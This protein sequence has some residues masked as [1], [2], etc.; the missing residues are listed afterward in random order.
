VGADDWDDGLDASGGARLLK[1]KQMLEW[2]DLLASLRTA[3]RE[4][5]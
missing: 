2:S 3:R 1:T 5:G 4:G